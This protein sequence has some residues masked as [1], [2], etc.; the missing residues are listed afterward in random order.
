LLTVD[1]IT[2]SLVVKG[3]MTRELYLEFLEKIVVCLDAV[4]SAMVY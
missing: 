2:A 3:S 1:G 4:F